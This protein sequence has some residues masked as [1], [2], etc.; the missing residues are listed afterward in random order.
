M[1]KKATFFYSYKLLLKVIVQI[2]PHS[3][4]QLTIKHFLPQFLRNPL[5]FLYVKII[6]DVPANTPIKQK[7]SFSMPLNILAYRLKDIKKDF[8]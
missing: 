5:T 3:S 8:K 1:E 6:L 2:H 7:S 4:H